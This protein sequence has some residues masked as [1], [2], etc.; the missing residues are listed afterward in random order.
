MLSDVLGKL[1]ATT[2]LSSSA[3]AVLALEWRSKSSIGSW[4][5][6]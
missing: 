4:Q 5:K 2:E 3:P 6:D 1:L